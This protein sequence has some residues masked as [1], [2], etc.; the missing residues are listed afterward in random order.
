MIWPLKVV[1]LAKV[2]VKLHGHICK[3]AGVDSI[4]IQ[5]DQWW[6][7]ETLLENLCQRFKDAFHQAI[8]DPKTG[9]LNRNIIVMVNGENI[10][11]HNILDTKLNDGDLVLIME[12]IVGG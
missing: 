10:V 2:M 11:I 1:N 4:Y 5:A 12:P 3:I 8:F 6:T 7:V 9:N